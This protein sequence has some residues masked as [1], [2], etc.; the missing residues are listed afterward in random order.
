[1]HL[2]SNLT[3]N[4]ESGATVHF[5][6]NFAD[7]LP[8]VQMRW[9]GLTMQTFSPLFYA[10]G[11]ENITLCGRGTIDGQGAK[12]WAEALRLQALV[13]EN[14]VE[15]PTT[16][17]K[18]W[19]DANP[20]YE[21]PP[22]WEKYM[23][24]HFF[25]PSFVQF[26]QCNNILIEGITI[27]N[28]PF[29]TINPEFCDNLTIHGI[30][31]NNDAHSPNTDGIDPSSCSN[32]HISDCHINVGDDCICI[33]SGRDADG[34]KWG[35]PCENITITNCTM[36]AG[37]G[38]VVIGSEMSGGVKKVT[39]S[40][41][42][43]DGTDTGIRMKASRGR[44]GVVEEIRVD[45]IIMSNI[46]KNAFIFDL[47]YDGVS[48]QEP[49]SERTPIFRNIHIS[50]ITGNSARSIGYIKGLEEMPIEELSFSNINLTAKDGFSAKTARNIQFHNVDFT[51]E[52]G[53]SFSFT[54][55]SD[56]VLDNVRSKRPIKGKAIVSVINTNNLFIN[57]CFQPV[58]T[59]V[60][61]ES[62]DS[63]LVWGNNFFN[64]VT[65]QLKEIKP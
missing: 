15:P 27:I 55:C 53:A 45:N 60:F 24:R 34:R 29:W 18:M 9:A 37:H 28:S 42:V 58:Q 59:D 49:V 44:G 32:V 22:Y 1:M 2:K 54:D 62:K 46:K 43:F 30:T 5:S 52:K 39:I 17:Q 21:I 8:F 4:I 65:I 61:C 36:L 48:P 19:V 14:K 63:E 50:N 10:V 31:I 11:E 12:W 64:Q 25:P 56:I 3:V 47:Y 6:D 35:K 20:N 33:K 51:V 26:F 13:K 41:C 7:Y 38:G 40:N 23:E 16:Y 57:N